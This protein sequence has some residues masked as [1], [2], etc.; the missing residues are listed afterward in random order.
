MIYP[1]LPI[2]HSVLTQSNEFRDPQY[3]LRSAIHKGVVHMVFTDSMAPVSKEDLQLI[4]SRQ[5]KYGN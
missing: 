4:V 5:H 2:T 1:S 3:R